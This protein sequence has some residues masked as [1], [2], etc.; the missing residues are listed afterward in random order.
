[1]E[2]Q[3]KQRRRILPSFSCLS[4]LRKCL[5]LVWTGLALLF[6]WDAL[7]CQVCASSPSLLRAHAIRVSSFS[8]WILLIA[9]CWLILPLLLTSPE[10]VAWADRDNQ[11]LT[12]LLF[13]A[14]AGGVEVG[15]IRP[16]QAAASCTD[17]GECQ[18]ALQ[19]VFLL[20]VNNYYFPLTFPFFWFFLVQTQPLSVPCPNERLH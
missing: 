14:R 10:Q 8:E 13:A 16:Y 19:Q 15:R 1:M 4:V 3:Q 6:W 9:F 7:E 12:L 5:L 11:H 20:S 17:S 2:R 18:L